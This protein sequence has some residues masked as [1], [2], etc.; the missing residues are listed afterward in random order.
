MRGVVLILIW[1]VLA[2][3]AA[4]VVFPWTLIMRDTRLLFKV[5][6]WIVRAGLPLVG[7]RVVVHGFDRLPRGA[8][9]VMANHSSNLDPP[10]LI[11]L[12]PGRVV[13]YLKASLMRIPVL[14]YAMRLAGFIPVRRDGTVESARAASAAAQRAL[15]EGNCLVLFPEGTRSRDGSLLPFKKGPFFLAMESGVPVVPVSIAGA[16]ELLPKGS[17]RLKS[18]TVSVTFHPT[19]HPQDFKDKEALMGAVRSAIESGLTGST[20]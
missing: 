17:T 2:L 6:F 1:T 14:G 12:L 9:I 8:S 16:T 13:I 5:G 18:G 20:W 3:P 19:L 7:V 4:L 10:A 11:P 15:A